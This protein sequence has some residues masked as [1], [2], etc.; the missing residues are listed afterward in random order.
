MIKLSDSA[1]NA[2][3]PDAARVKD[4]PCN[5]CGRKSTARIRWY[6]ENGLNLFAVCNDHFPVLKEI[7][8]KMQK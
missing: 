4:S 8:R 3:D 5:V 2:L 7:V 1:Y 6:L